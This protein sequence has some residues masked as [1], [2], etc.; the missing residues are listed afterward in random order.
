MNIITQPLWQFATMPLFALTMGC[1]AA[2]HAYPDGCVPC[3][4][5]APPPL[6]YMTYCGSCPAPT[7]GCC[8]ELHGVESN[9]DEGI[10]SEGVTRDGQDE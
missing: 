4:Y 1:A 10:P 7:A 3:E 6:P 5:C 2:Y 9:S 8:S